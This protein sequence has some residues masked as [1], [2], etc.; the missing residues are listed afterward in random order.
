MIYLLIKTIEQALTSYCSANWVS[1][2]TI[3]IIYLGSGQGRPHLA[4][5]EAGVVGEVGLVVHGLGPRV[6]VASPRQT[7]HS[8]ERE[9]ER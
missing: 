9:R 3:S 8:L 6:E 1:P 7:V 4:D 5:Q 2:A